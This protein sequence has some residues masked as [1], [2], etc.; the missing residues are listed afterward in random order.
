M[1]EDLTGA[2]HEAERRLQAVQLAGDADALDDLLDDCLIY[3]GGPNG[4]RYTRQD[5]LEIQRSHTQMLSRV[6]RKT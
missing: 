2:L 6:E 5:D 1:I 4:A 3:T